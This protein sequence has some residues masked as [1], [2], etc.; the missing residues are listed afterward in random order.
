MDAEYN[1]RVI[2]KKWQAEWLKNKT[3][4]TGRGQEKYYLLEM[5]PYPSGKIHMGHVRNYSIGDVVARYQRMLGRDV[6]HPMGWDA[7]GMPAENAAIANSVHP[8]V[9][10]RKNI[11]EMR[12]Q[13]QSLGFSYDWDRELATCDPDYYRWEQLF[14]T[15][16]LAKG[17]VYKKEA[18]VN[19]CE[20][21]QTVLAN[22]QV[23]NGCCWRCGKETQDKDLNQWFFKITDYAEEL[24][25]GCKELEG[26]WPE[27]VIT[28]QKNWIGKS[29]GANINFQV[30]GLDEVEIS[31]FTTRQDTL[32]GATF[33][34][35][36]PDHPLAAELAAGTGQE[37]AVAD[38]AEKMRLQEISDRDLT[39]LEK[40]GVFTGRYAI[41]PVTGK[42]MPIY[43]ANFVLSGYGTGAVMAVP[44]HDQRDFEFARMYD[45]PMVVV[46]QP[47]GE[48]LT[49]KTM[50]EAYTGTGSLVNSGE[51]DGLENVKALDQIA[52]YLKE[53]SIGN[54]AITYR[55]RDW[56]VSRQRY[57]GAPIP[58]IYCDKC[59][60]VPVPA[61]DLPVCLPE[62]VEL[63]KAGGS[64]LAMHA[65]FVNT[66][67][68]QCSAPARRET[69]TMDTFVESSWY[70]MRYACAGFADAP[71]DK[72][73]VNNWLP[74]DHYVG[75][76]EHA[77]LHL[78]Y[79]RFFTRVLRDLG[80][81]NFSEPFTKLL[82]QGMVIKDGAKMSKSKGNVVDPN[83]LIKR[84]GADTA[85]MFS[86]FASPPELDLEW[87]DQG[88]EGGYRFLN[89][90]WRYVHD[91]LPALKEV[92]AFAGTMAEVPAAYTAL[93][94]KIHQTITKV[95]TDI[96][97]R[98][99][100]NTAISAV[101]ELVNELK[102]YDLEA[103]RADKVL[104]AILREAVET[105]VL[106]LAPIVPHI[107]EELWF[108]LGNQGGISYV[109]VP[110]ADAEALV[111]DTVLVVV[112]VNGKVRERLQVPLDM[113]KAE[114]EKQ[115]LDSAKVQKHLAGKTPRKIIVVPN[116]LVNIVV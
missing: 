54:K 22:E 49:P 102:K 27:R 70:Y 92:E 91:L 12:T 113:A 24:L 82:T 30:D 51:F 107:T 40:E 50:T 28:M 25:E 4:A 47:E 31:V 81:I 2:E 110:V 6:L 87:N 41:N 103:A 96:E 106:L 88:V 74:V 14:F 114:V 98:M 9:W 1:P 53:K 73:V 23:E 89:R 78:L 26:G 37:Q 100:F 66:V 46:I 7:F 83:A 112:Q 3:F 115:A 75:G 108:E 5:F 94:R 38:F 99:H 10:T 55:L 39:Q 18:K 80:Y 116:K 11:D 45:L 64:P 20:D 15:E 84:Y 71:L 48:K 58:I 36:A 60:I 101:M 86:L 105:V 42:K 68:P 17:L 34:S 79:S 76:I 104:A 13:L 62:D 35:L 65:D 33:M 8:A 21:C 32:F 29:V 109:P 67:C 19:W 97:K 69:D 52:S 72:E 57:W 16:M 61:Q 56:G 111:E 63:G 95:R 59:G 43:L 93:R 90:L 44:A 85:R 77:I